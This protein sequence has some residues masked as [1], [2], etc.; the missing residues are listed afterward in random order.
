MKIQQKTDFY[1]NQSPKLHDHQTFM[2]FFRHRK[3]AGA[4]ERAQAAQLLQNS[5]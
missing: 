1:A 5:G 3:A 2:Q 4:Y